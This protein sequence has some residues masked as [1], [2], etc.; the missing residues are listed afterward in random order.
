MGDRRGFRV[1]VYKEL[2][3]K[4]KSV[5]TVIGWLNYAYLESLEI[6][7]KYICELNFQALKKMWIVLLKDVTAQMITMLTDFSK[8]INSLQLLQINLN[9]LQLDVN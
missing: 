5:N 2:V 9:H 8:R 7:Q 6:Q 3:I 1:G 4:I